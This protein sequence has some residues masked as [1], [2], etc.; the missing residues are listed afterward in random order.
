MRFANGGTLHGL[1]ATVRARILR[2]STEEPRPVRWPDVA[3]FIQKAA[4]PMRIAARKIKSS[5]AFADPPGS[6][7]KARVNSAAKPPGNARK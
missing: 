1:D 2:V 4:S 6:E 3:V 7:Q 5:A